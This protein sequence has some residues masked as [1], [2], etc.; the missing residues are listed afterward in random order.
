MDKLVQI[1]AEIKPDIDFKTARSLMDDGIL[2]SVDVLSIIA[3]LKEHYNIE[4]SL[5]DIDPNDFNSAEAIMALIE[6][7]K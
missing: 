2:D 3:A 4:V 5:L 7:K 1:L 6:R